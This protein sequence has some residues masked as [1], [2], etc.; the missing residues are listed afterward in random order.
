MQHVPRLC[1]NFAHFLTKKALNDANTAS[2]AG[3]L[4]NGCTVFSLLF[5]MKESFLLKKKEKNSII[6]CYNIL[7]FQSTL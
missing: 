1:N 6:N 2:M 7:K 5:L 4:S 3:Q